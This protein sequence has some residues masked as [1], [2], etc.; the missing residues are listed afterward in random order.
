MDKKFK[1]VGLGV[2]GLS[3]IAFL[4]FISP[5]IYVGF[6]FLG[7]LIVKWV[8]GGIVTDGLNTLFNTE[9]FAPSIIPYICAALAMVGSY[10][11]S[12]QTNNNK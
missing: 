9:R 4:L 10:F 5:I 1:G 12:S 6:G 2:A 7:G 3:A 11:K 8:F